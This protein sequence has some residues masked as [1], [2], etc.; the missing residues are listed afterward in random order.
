[1]NRFDTV[2]NGAAVWASYYRE[3][4]DKFVED[5]LHVH[6]RLFQRILIVMMFWSTTF[7]LIACR[8]LGKTFICAVYCVTRCILFPRTQICI[9]SGTRGQAV[10]VLQKIIQEM[11]PKSR[12]LCLEIDE[13]HT[14]I[15]TEKAQV[16]FKNN[17]VIRVVTASD[18]ARG[19][20]CNV[21][22][23]D[24]FRLVSK[25]TIDTVLKH[26]LKYKR[27][28]D[29]IELTDEE[30]LAE[31]DKEKNLSMYLSSA[32]YKNHW[33]YTKCTD[34][35]NAML[36]PKRRQFVCAFPYQ[37]SLLE[38]LADKESIADDM[39]E[40]NFSEVKFS[41]EME[42]MFWGATENAFFDF[43]SISRNRKLLF[44]MLQESVRS[45]LG[46]APQFKITDKQR[47]EIRILSADIALMSSG[48]HKNDAS[49]L[50]VNQLLPGKSGR[51]LSNI[52]YP[53]SCEGKRTD[54]QALIIRRLF[55]EYLCDYIVLDTMGE[56]LPRHTVTCGAKCGRNRER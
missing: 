41:M 40:T 8:G 22:V 17:S 29:Y 16:A 6:L 52:V 5:Y 32:W 19:N 21:L 34:T 23:I 50:Y 38:K 7:V 28:P 36:D 44:P 14:Q 30:R 39:A 43:E 18:T 55:D 42:A 10:L 45:M 2:L 53:E 56:P 1:M 24:E 35:F 12:E 51:Y 31:Y 26:F 11:K 4:P 20:R 25:D 48:R 46:G 9:V 13:R 3:N 49:S 47:N 27:Q 15:N 37:L 54:D 33:S